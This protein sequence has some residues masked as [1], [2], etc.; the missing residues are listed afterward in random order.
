M[1]VRC[2][3]N[4]IDSIASQKLTRVLLQATFGYLDGAPISDRGGGLKGEKRKR[5][6][7]ARKLRA[8]EGVGSGDQI[9]SPSVVCICHAFSPSSQFWWN[10]S[11]SIASFV[12]VVVCR[13]WYLLF[14]EYNV[15]GLK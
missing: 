13:V 9:L 5:E 15:I 8:K 12:C 1:H 4:V 10:M 3:Y 11:P 2:E 6:K 14:C 7:I